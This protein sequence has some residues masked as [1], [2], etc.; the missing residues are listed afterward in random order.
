MY[1]TD[2]TDALLRAEDRGIA[3]GMAEE[4][5]KRNEEN[6]KRM[7]RKGYSVETVAEVLDL[8]EKEVRTIL[9]M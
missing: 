2:M 8:P 4:R 7:Y 3:K 9:G 5:Q 6:V 1:E